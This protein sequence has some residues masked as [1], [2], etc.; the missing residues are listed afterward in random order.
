MNE[1]SLRELATTLLDLFVNR[2]DT[3]CLQQKNGAYIRIEQTLTLKVLEQH[4]EGEIAVGAYQLAKDNT[5]KYVCFDLDPEKLV[6]PSAA[7]AVIV[8]QC[9]KKTDPE[10]KKPR[11]HKQALLLEASR[12]P[13]PSYHIWVI[14]QPPIPATLAR[15]L[16]LKILEHA[17][18]SPKLVEVF[19][20][21]DRLTEFRPFGNFVKLP[22]G[23]HQVVGKWSKL[24]D[25]ETMA[26]LPHQVLCNVQ[27][28]SFSNKEIDG[29]LS[30]HT[31][32]THV[33]MKLDASKLVEPLKDNEEPKIVRLLVKY[34]Q[35]GYRNQLELYFLGW[36]MKRGISYESARRVIDAV[37]TCTGDEEKQA[38]LDLVDYHYK[39]RAS[40]LP[41]LKGATGLREVISA[42][43][44]ESGQ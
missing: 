16:G 22:L 13:D 6:N 37:T 14:F 20:K 38:R 8:D 17:N 28:V 1:T 15:W 12:Y 44:R 43:L 34:W 35:P 19:P 25:L 9:L 18:I 4:L 40:M 2:V 7:V 26:P 41:E 21:Q 29:F 10:P 11:F 39:N 5:V 27:G 42:V 30:K 3:Y 31:Y 33:A 23:R 32:K 24:L 36:A